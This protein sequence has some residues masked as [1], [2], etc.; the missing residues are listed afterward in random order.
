MCLCFGDCLVVCPLVC[1]FV[2]LLVFGFMGLGVCFCL[3]VCVCCVSMGLCVFCLVFLCYVR[4]V[5]LTEDSRS[6]M[7]LRL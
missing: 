1:V 5:S 2:G 6:S 7:T 3:C 4:F